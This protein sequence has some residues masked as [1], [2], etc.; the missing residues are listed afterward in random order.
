[1][2]AKMSALLETEEYGPERNRARISA[3]AITS[4]SR[5]CSIEHYSSLVD[6]A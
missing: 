4:F 1:M 3:G 5:F 6:D 2:C